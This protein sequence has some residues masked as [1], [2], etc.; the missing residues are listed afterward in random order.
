MWKMLHNSVLHAVFYLPE[1]NHRYMYKDL[2][3]YLQPQDMN[4]FLFYSW[5]NKNSLS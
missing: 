3:V 1:K 4:L 2:Y 5:A